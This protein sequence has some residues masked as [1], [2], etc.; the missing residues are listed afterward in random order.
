MEN[1]YKI[2]ESLEHLE[3]KSYNYLKNIISG[4]HQNKWKKIKQREAQNKEN[5]AAEISSKE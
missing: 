3:K 2:R 4:Y 5:N 1:N